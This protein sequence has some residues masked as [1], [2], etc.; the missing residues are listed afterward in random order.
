MHDHRIILANSV[1]EIERLAA[2]D[3]VVFTEDLKPVDI[4]RLSIEYVL[5]M[6]GPETQ[7]ESK[8]RFIRGLCHR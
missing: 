2:I 7:A 8:K 6:F 3:H 5:V 1:Q 4:L